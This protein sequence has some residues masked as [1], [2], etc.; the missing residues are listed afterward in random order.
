MV[1]RV[2]IDCL[3]KELQLQYWSDLHNSS[4]DMCS[5]LKEKMKMNKSTKIGPIQSNPLSVL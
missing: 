5:F 4:F 1:L 2:N 3:R